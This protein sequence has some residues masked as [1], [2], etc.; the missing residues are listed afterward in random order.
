VL[1]IIIFFLGVVPDG[2]TGFD[3]LRFFSG[4]ESFYDGTDAIDK[5]VVFFHLAKVA[6]KKAA[7]WQP[8]KI[9]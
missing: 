2:T 5:L 9:Q 3:F 4:V 1:A 6:N 8:F 7:N